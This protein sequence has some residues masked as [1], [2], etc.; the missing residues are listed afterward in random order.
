MSELKNVRIK[1]DELTRSLDFKPKVLG[2]GLPAALATALKLGADNLR[3]RDA[4]RDW[5]NDITGAATVLLWIEERKDDDQAFLS[6]LGK[7]LPE[8]AL[9]WTFHAMA[10]LTVDRLTGDAVQ[11]LLETFGLR[12]G[13]CANTG[14]GYYA[15]SFKRAP[16]VA[17]EEER[18]FEDV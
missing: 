4:W 17:V 6:A 14:F 10:M 3:E 7:R 12:D 16:K 5:I 8:G 18:Y 15:R 2:I 9:L 1:G 11:K 13:K